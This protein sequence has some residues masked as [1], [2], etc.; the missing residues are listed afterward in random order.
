MSVSNDDENKVYGIVLRTPPVN[1]Y[2]MDPVEPLKYEK[3]L[4]KARIEKFILNNPHLVTIEMQPD[5]KKDSRDEE[6]EKEIKLFLKLSEEVDDANL[7]RSK[8][9]LLLRSGIKRCR[10]GV[11]DEAEQEERDEQGRESRRVER[12]KYLLQA[13]ERRGK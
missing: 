1:G 10:F 6:A 12:K 13:R 11:E 4:I 8:D 7:W 9:R 2:A 5:P 3:P